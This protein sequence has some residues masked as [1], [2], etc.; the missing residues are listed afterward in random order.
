Q[1]S[2]Y[3]FGEHTKDTKFLTSNPSLSFQPMFYCLISQTHNTAEIARIC[4]ECKKESFW[5]RGEL[6]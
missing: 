1:C 4:E 3:G 2:I 5:Y 6:N